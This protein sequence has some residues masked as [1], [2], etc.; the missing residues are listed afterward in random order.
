MELNDLVLENIKNGKK[1]E[2]G[3]DLFYKK[4]EDYSTI[5]VETPVCYCPFDIQETLDK[6][7]TPWKARLSASMKEC[8][9][10]VKD[11]QKFEDKIFKIQKHVDNMFLPED[12]EKR[13]LGG[14]TISNNHQYA[15]LFQMKISYIHGEPDVV[16]WD[17][18]RKELPIT[19]VSKG[20]YAK[21]IISL[22][23]C[24]ISKKYRGIDWVI[25]Q[26]MLMPPLQQEKKLSTFAFRKE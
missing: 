14:L 26:I 5:Q 23:K 6:G 4:N 24:W 15:N 25:K 2:R 12:K 3:F 21:F 10:N 17:K 1:T 13:L 11:I 19:D 20:V 16:V 9:Y 18:K 7:G 22:D 8:S